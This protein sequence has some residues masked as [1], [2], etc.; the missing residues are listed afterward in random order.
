MQL[1][2][3]DKVVLLLTAADPFDVEDLAEVV[4]VAIRDVDQVCLYESLGWRW[5]DL[6]G[7]EKGFDPEEAGVYPFDEA[8]WCWSGEQRRESALECVGVEEHLE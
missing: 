1:E 7:F 6:Q 8:C 5:S 3:L 2:K 4:V